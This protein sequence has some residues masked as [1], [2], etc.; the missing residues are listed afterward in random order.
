[1]GKYSVNQNI[2]RYF[3]RSSVEEG[4]RD[5]IQD[6]A[7]DL[8]TSVSSAMRR[9]ILL[10]AHCEEQHGHTKMPV[11]YEIFKKTLSKQT[12]EQVKEQADFYLNTDWIEDNAND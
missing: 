9:L 1:M 8:G 12:E 2:K 6:Y 3:V 10:G 4:L 7:N 11:S 5:F